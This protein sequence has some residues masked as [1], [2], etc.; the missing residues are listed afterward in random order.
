MAGLERFSLRQRAPET[1]MFAVSSRGRDASV[2]LRVRVSIKLMSHS[3]SKTGI[4]EE[5]RSCVAVLKQFCRSSIVLVD[6]CDVIIT[7]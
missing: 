2:P 7:R 4:I 5:F 3:V 6:A 1:R